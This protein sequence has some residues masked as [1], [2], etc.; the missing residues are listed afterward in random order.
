MTVN[1]FIKEL[2]AI[3]PDLREKEVIIIASNGLQFEPKL[4]Q[5]LINPY[6]IFGGIGNV[7]NMV[8]TFD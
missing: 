2:Q 3:R 7:K 6:N 1:D 5:Q 8:I 4:K